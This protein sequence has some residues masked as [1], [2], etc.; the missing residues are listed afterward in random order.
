MKK[1]L[2][3]ALPLI[4][5]TGC[6]TILNEDMQKIN[7][8]STHDEIRGTIDGVPFKGPGVVSV[9]RSRSDKTIMIETPSCQREVVLQSSVDPKFFI[10]I[11]SGGVFGSTT[12]FVSERMWKYQDQ[13]V[14]PCK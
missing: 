3:V 9:K 7:V 11:L 13:V 4:F 14:V 10:N 2:L 6:A 8:S 12:D 5:A 1:A